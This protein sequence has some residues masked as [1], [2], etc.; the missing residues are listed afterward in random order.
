MTENT[1]I[2]KT[3]VSLGPSGRA[4]AQAV[5]QDLLQ[6]LYQHLTMER[7]ASV[8]YFSISLW[9]KERDLNGFSSFFLEE[10][11]AEMD[12][13]YKF[14]DYIIARGQ[15]VNLQQL[16]APIQEWES[17]EEIIS[18]AFNME[19]DLT[20]SLQQIYSISERSADTRTNVFLDPIVEAQINSEDEFATILGKVKFAN[21]QPSALLILDSELNK[22]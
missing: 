6:N 5:D 8:Q 14:S 18:F 19:S 3:P 22:K 11:K 20:A 1:I 2:K 16:P 13:S 9:F 12:H 21:N 7:N 10:S 17:I 15:T 4:V